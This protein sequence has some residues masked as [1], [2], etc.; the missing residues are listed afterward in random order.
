MALEYLKQTAFTIP[1]G[2]TIAKG[3]MTA[4]SRRVYFVVWHATQPKMLIYDMS[5]RRQETAEFNLHALGA[6]R[7]FDAVAIDAENVYLM[8]NS[9]ALGVLADVYPYSRQGRAGRQFALEGITSGGFKNKGKSRAFFSICVAIFSDLGFSKSKSYA[10]RHALSHSVMNLLR[11]KGWA[12][13]G[14]GYDRRLPIYPSV[15][16]NCRHLPRWW[17]ITFI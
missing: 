3:A 12:R 10:V 17:Y 9:P 15:V 14:E 2:Y 8:S 7:S 1:S 11:G 5:G 13:C 6:D 4:E 16:C